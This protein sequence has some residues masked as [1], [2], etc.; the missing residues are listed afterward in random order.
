MGNGN[1]HDEPNRRGMEQQYH[2]RILAGVL[3][4]GR[5][6][7]IG[8]G[9]TLAAKQVEAMVS[10]ALCLYAAVGNAVGSSNRSVHRLSV[11]HCR[12]ATVHLF[13]ILICPGARV[14]PPAKKNDTIKLISCQSRR[15]RLRTRTAKRSNF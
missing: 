11:H 13:P 10:A 8:N 9:D 1:Q 7:C 6:V 2:P 5:A 12:H 15:G 3:S 4:S 14:S